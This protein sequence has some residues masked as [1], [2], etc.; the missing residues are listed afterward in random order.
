VIRFVD[1]SC[2]PFADGD[3]TRFSFVTMTATFCVWLCIYF[4]IYKGVKNS[5]YIV[6]CTVPLPIIFIIIMVINGLMLPGSANGVAKYLGG[7]PN[8]IIDYSALWSD[9][10]G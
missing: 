6:W 9:A 8:V 4:T 3:Q 1:D 7:E 2:K 10:A 5:S